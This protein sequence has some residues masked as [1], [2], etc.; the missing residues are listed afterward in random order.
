MVVNVT[1]RR[2]YDEIGP[3]VYTFYISSLQPVPSGQKQQK[4]YVVKCLRATKHRTHL[5][6]KEN[7]FCTCGDFVHNHLAQG[8]YCKHIV[9]IRDLCDHVGGVSR[10]PV[11]RTVSATQPLKPFETLTSTKGRSNARKGRPNGP[12]TAR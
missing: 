8:G 2:A 9:I 7:W 5:R 3:G 6:H 12:R 11:G 10:F 1:V 4:E